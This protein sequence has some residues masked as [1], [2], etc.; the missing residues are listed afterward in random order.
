MPAGPR[1]LDDDVFDGVAAN[2]V[3]PAK[4]GACAQQAPER[5]IVEGG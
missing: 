1:V 4:I 5:A 3:V 2:V